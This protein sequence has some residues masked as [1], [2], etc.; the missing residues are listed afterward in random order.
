MAL[1]QFSINNAKPTDKTY[2]VSDGDGL[3]LRIHPKGGRQWMLRFR[4]GGKANMMS[5]GPYPAVSLLQARRKR[6]KVKE[7]I[8]AGIDPSLSRKL[9]KL[10]ASASAQNTFGAVA[11]EHLANLE[12]NGAAEQT[13]KKNR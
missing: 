8:A 2:L 13:L 1:S 4:F 11:D 6:D 3:H 10:A 5:L 7:Q 9:E 12:K